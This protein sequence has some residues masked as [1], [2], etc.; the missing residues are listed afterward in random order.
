MFDF[1]GL[2]LNLDWSWVYN[3][4]EQPIYAIAW[5]FILNGGWVLFLVAFIWG[6]WRNFVYYKNQKFCGKQ[7]YI[8]LAL[9]VP[10]NNI[11]TPR[12]VENI[13]TALAGAHMPLEWIEKN[14]K[15]ELQL[16]FSC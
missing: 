12:A 5:H 13:F 4:G 15:G 6:G 7:T 8:M 11:Q 10:K 16:G 3:L 14:I 2:E 1:I 9:D